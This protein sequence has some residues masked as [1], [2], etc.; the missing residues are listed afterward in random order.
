[1]TQYRCLSCSVIFAEN[2]NET[3]ASYALSITRWLHATDTVC[4][5]EKIHV[6]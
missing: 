5:R 3:R 2:R 1:L 6:G 4:W